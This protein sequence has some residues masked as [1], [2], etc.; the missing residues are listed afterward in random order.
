M[1]ITSEPFITKVKDLLSNHRLDD[2]FSKGNL[3]RL[4]P[5]IDGFQLKNLELNER[6]KT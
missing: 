3:A 2:T 5:E 1:K 6:L 4:M